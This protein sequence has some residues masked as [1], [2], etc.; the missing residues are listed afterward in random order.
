MK[1]ILVLAANP[2]G[3]S[4]LRLDEEVREIR[5]GLKRSEHRG[6]FELKSRWAAR[7]VDMQRAILEEKPQIVHFS[8]LGKSLFFYWISNGIYVKRVVLCKYCP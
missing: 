8:G 3:T 1:T 7:P 4:Q 6:S 5:E 2:K